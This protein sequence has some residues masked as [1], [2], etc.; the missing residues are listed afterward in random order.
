M[1]REELW[2][3]LLS[4][5]TMGPVAHRRLLEQYGSPEEIWLA[6]TPPLTEKQ[7]SEFFES[8]KLIGRKL[9]EWEAAKK[10]GIRMVTVEDEDYPSRWA[11][12]YDSPYGFFL[13]GKLPPEPQPAVAMVGARKCTPHGKVTAERLGEE[14]AQSGVAVISGLAEGI[15]G[16]SHRGALK[17]NGYTLAVLGC[18]IDTCYPAIH[19]TLYEE[20]KERGGIISEYS[21]GKPALP[22]HFPLRNRLISGLSDL[23]LVVEAREKSGSL[24]TVDQALEQGRD[25]MAVPGRPEDILSQGCHK[26]LREGAGLC[27][28]AEDVLRQLGIEE[29]ISEHENH[30]IAAS[31]ELSH[32]ELRVLS[33][34]SAEPC[35]VD[36]IAYN[37][38]YPAALLSGIL[39]GLELKGC[40]RRAAPGQ[41]QLIRQF[42]QINP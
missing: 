36:S 13:L 35:H 41:Y 27:T 1:E 34:M 15:D 42:R 17:G 38:G 25:V 9:K 19:R 8:R 12:L 5:D 29:R 23:V 20:L 32:E 11:H 18:G 31:C 33:C 16:A 3:W 37:T 26:L 28:C 30:R 2:Y 40:V 14:L 7:R 22:V 39:F 6:K 10:K 24:I 21:P 4:M